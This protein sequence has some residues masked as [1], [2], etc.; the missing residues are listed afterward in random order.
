VARKPTREFQRYVAGASAPDE[1][2][3]LKDIFDYARPGM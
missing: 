3:G 1:I 2:G